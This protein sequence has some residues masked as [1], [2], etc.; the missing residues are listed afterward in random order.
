MNVINVKKQPEYRNRAIKYFQDKWASSESLKV[1]E[2]SISRS[3]KTASPL[4]IWYLLEE[5]G[6]IIGCCGVIT[7]DFISCMD[8]YPWLCALYIEEDMRGRSLGKMLI[9]QAITDSRLAGFK[10]IYLCTD[11]TNYYEKYGFT[12]IGTGYHPWGESSKVYE[13]I[14]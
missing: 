11:H 2:D 14:I 10:S 3:I 8:L 12:F 1:Y 4:P 9:D 5:Q 13:C 6:R 7:N